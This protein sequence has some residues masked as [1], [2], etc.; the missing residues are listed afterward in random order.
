MFAA[1]LLAL[2]EAPTATLSSPSLIHER[3][4][5]KFCA[6]SGSMPSVLRELVGVIIFTSHAV[7]P[8]V[9]DPVL[10]TWNRGELRRVILLSVTLVALFSWM[11]RGFCWLPPLFAMAESPHQLWPA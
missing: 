6:W 7:N 3:V 4:M 11:K 9:P 5:V 1:A 10:D 2:P 8:L